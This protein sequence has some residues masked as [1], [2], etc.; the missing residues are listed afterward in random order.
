MKLRC[1]LIN[2]V[3]IFYH[4]RGKDD[5]SVV[6]TGCQKCSFTVVLAVTANGKCPPFVIFKRRTIPKEQ[7]PIRI[8]V[9]ANENGWMTESMMKYWINESW[10]E[11]PNP[12]NDSRGSL[13]I[14]DSARSHL[15]ETTKAAIKEHSKVAVIPAGLTK[16]SQPLDI[17]VNKSFKSHLKQHWEDWI[18]NS[19]NHSYTNSGRTRRVSYTEICKWILESFEAVSTECIKN[20]FRKALEEDVET[21]YQEFSELNLDD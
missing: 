19:D 13:L 20:G 14:L 1:F 16:F 9:K 11:R 12:S 8:I 3:V 18:S 6:T 21:L 5:V 10:K 4:Q 2:L 15:T 17:S 7:F